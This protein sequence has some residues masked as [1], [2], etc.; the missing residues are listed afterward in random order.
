MSRRRQQRRAEKARRHARPSWPSDPAWPT[1]APKAANP[2]RVVVRET[3][4][5][6]RLAYTRSQ[7]AQA[8]GVSP[9]TIRRLLPY[10]ETIEMPWGA[11]LIPVDE[12]ERL[13]AERRRPA[14]VRVPQAPAGRPAALSPELVHRIRAERAVGKSFGQIARDLNASGTPTAHGGAQWWPSTVRAVFRR[15]PLEATPVPSSS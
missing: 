7:A 10:V 3:T 1:E 8:L 9:S 11:K 15:S 5:V 4:Q 13:L 14:R 2:A 6:E 12:L